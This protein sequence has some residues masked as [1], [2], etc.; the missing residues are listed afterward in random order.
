M[1]LERGVLVR[2]LGQRPD[3]SEWEGRK[4][5][6]HTKSLVVERRQRG[7]WL[8]EGVVGSRKCLLGWERTE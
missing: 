5:R 2:W 6:G 3:W 7:W 4:D 8:L 1:T